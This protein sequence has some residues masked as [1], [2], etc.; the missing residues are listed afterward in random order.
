MI[1]RVYTIKTSDFRRVGVVGSQLGSGPSLLNTIVCREEENLCVRTRGIVAACLRSTRNQ[2]GRSGFGPTGEIEEV[3]VLAE[4]I[5]IVRAF[6]FHRREE[7]HDTCPSWRPEPAG[8]RG[9]PRLIDGQERIGWELQGLK[10]LQRR[11]W[12]NRYESFRAFRVLNMFLHPPRS[13]LVA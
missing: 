10:E 6:G 9:S 1:E 7:D 5:K 11:V 13:Q 2:N 12:Q 4:S 3:V 8:E